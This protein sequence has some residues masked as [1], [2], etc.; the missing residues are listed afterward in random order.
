[1]GGKGTHDVLKHIHKLWEKSSAHLTTDES[2][3]LAKLLT[4]Y[5]DLD[6]GEYSDI[7][8]LSLL[9]R[10]RQSNMWRTL[11]GF[12]NEE[13]VHL[14]SLFKMGVIEP[15]TSGLA[16]PPSAR[17]KKRWTSLSLY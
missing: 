17:Q 8:I 7:C 1:M 15:S 9:A 12:E 5:T 14:D 6:L 11:L 10:L 13:K 3:E 2:G 4:E 16:S